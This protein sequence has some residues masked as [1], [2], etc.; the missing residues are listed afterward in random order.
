[1]DSWRTSKNQSRTSGISLSTG[2][3]WYLA[4]CLGFGIACIF[5]GNNILYLVESILLGAIVVS[6]FFSEFNLRFLTLE[7][8]EGQAQAG[9]NCQDIWVIENHSKFSASN[10]CIGEIFQGKFLEQGRLW[11][12]G[13]K[14]KVQVRFSKTFPQR[15]LVR[16][17]HLAVAT[18][19]P[20]GFGRKTRFFG[21]GGERTIWPRLDKAGF[22]NRKID[23]AQGFSGD[24]Q[25]GDLKAIDP[26]G[27]AKKVH[28]PTWAKTGDFFSLPQNDNLLFAVEISDEIPEELLEKKI[29]EA[30]ELVWLGQSSLILRVK[31]SDKK[32]L[33]RR[34]AMDALAV[35]SLGG[36][37]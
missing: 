1:M 19:F 22:R 6:G 7:R 8:W 24:W 9:E 2:G 31:K 28:W 15:G 14:E 37:R 26:Y 16:W 18:T 17:D 34:R 5:S 12:L 4:L 3:K 13:S 20:F 32:I 27:D 33:N 10:I 23:R 11:S 36:V 35:F 21:A 30:A 25:Y 29:S